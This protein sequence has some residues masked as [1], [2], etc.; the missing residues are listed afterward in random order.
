M[1]NLQRV[2]F[3]LN[4]YR[5][6]LQESVRGFCKHHGAKLQY[7]QISSCGDSLIREVLSSCPNLQHIVIPPTGMSLMHGKVEWIDVYM[8]DGDT[9]FLSSIWTTPM[10]TSGMPSLKGVRFISPFLLS[11]CPNISLLIP[12]DLVPTSSDE[13]SCQFLEWGVR[14]EVAHLS[15][16]PG[17]I[18]LQ[19]SYAEGQDSGDESYIDDDAND[20]ESEHSDSS[21]VWDFY[22]MADDHEWRH[23]Y[24]RE[25]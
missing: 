20:T 13:F 1:P 11:C 5:G 12:P 6:D 2:T 4:F 10:H 14:H 22:D 21:S 7:L 15:H 8:P 24:E 23:A 16:L 17:A 9:D 25:L 3:N 18:W 19:E